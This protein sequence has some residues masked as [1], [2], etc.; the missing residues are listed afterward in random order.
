MA[1][2]DVYKMKSTPQESP[3]KDAIL[4]AAD[5]VLYDVSTPVVE[6]PYSAHA[7]MEKY[8]SWWLAAAARVGWHMMEEYVPNVTADVV[9]RLVSIILMEPFVTH[10]TATVVLR[11]VGITLKE[12]DTIQRAR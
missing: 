4:F 7:L 10:F 11:S 1:V 12:P 8:N 2:D 3:L 6:L 5:V 9:L